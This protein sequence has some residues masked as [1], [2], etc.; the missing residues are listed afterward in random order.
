MSKHQIPENLTNIIPADKTAAEGGITTLSTKI[1]TATSVIQPDQKKDF[2]QIGPK[3]ESVIRIGQQAA[4]D[5]PNAMPA[6][7]TCDRIDKSMQNYDDFVELRGLLAPVME[8]IEETIAVNG[9]VAADELNFIYGNLSLA[10]T[11]NAALK[12]VIAP[13]TAYYEKGPRK[14]FSTMNLAKGTSISI[15]GAV[16]GTRVT[17]TGTSRISLDDGAETSGS[18]KKMGLVYVEPGS[19]VVIPPHV[20]AFL[21]TNLSATDPASFEIKLN[22]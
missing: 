4:H 17:N 8:I 21:V 6:G 22:A 11:K 5:N 1:A 13:I 19:S 12:K 10:A 3:L 2:Q 7:Y 14:G 15:T 16:P 9:I 18:W 20:T